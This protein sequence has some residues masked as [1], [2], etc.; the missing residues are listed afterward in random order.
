MVRASG[1]LF[2]SVTCCG[3]PACPWSGAKRPPWNNIQIVLGLGAG[4]GASS[5]AWAWTP[6]LPEGEAL[7]RK[8]GAA[9]SP[10]APPDQPGL[11]GLDS[12]LDSWEP[13]TQQLSF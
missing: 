3:A 2:V 6:S 12:S 4:E 5:A 9:L 1:P 7:T 8:A 13:C 10:R 11:P